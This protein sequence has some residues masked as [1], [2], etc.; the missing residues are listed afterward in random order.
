MI[1]AAV[2]LCACMLVFTLVEKLWPSPAPH[3]WW[4][5]PLLVDVCSWLIVP[6]AIGTGIML[7]VDSTNA[8]LPRVPFWPWLL[9]LQSA[10]RNLPLL[11]NIVIAFIAVDF[12]NYWLHRAYHH[13]PFLWSFHLM[14]H[15][16]ERIDWLSTL[17]VHPVSQ[18]LD[19]AMVTAFLLVVG[20]PVNALVAAHA[21]I[22]FS[23]VVTHANVP[24]TFGPLG[25]LFVSPIFHHWH[26]ARTDPGSRAEQPTNFGAALS[27][28]DS[29]FGT[30]RDA[31]KQPGRY[32]TDQSP[33]KGL[34]SLL[35]HPLRF[36]LPG[37]RRVDE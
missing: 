16:S 2:H 21:L 12:L 36:S 17:R 29:V 11:L 20:L 4:R 5:R 23:A 19:T 25:R 27:I 24:W 7:A 28:W 35:L 8:L 30:S 22:G 1:A 14:H 18:M 6:V 31:D 9:W 15:T 3:P 34:V 33:G 37:K 13:F 32:G 10:I 26:H